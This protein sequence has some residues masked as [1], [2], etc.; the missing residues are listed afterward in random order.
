MS[1][2]QKLAWFTLA[3]CVG[4]GLVYLLLWPLLGPSR[5]MG[6]FALLSLWSLSG[7]F[8][9]RQPKRVNFDERDRA[10]HAGAVKFAAGGV[11]L[12]FVICCSALWIVRRGVGSI[13]ADWLMN[14]VLFGA[15]VL[16][17]SWSAAALVLY[18]WKG[19]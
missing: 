7:R 6:A 11:Y 14:M 16:L 19:A 5:A 3:I 1:Q 15:I 4:T 2:Q 10:I 9:L 17:G 8:Y 12:Y 13:P 18:R